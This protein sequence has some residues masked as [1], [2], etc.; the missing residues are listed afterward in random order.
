MFTFKVVLIISVILLVF[1]YTFK[2]ILSKG[3]KKRIKLSIIGFVL[4]SPFLY[5]FVDSS[6]AGPGS[7]IIIFLPFI[8][9]FVGY[10]L[11]SILD[12]FS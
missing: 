11:G 10:I 8:G 9:G 3:W 6:G 5:I 4:F 1:G 2:L 7:G 12:Y